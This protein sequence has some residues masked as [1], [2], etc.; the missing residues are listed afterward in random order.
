MIRMTSLL[1]LLLPLPLPLTLTLPII[2]RLLIDL[3]FHQLKNLHRL[4]P[5]LLRL[6]ALTHTGAGADARTREGKRAT[7]HTGE[8]Q[9]AN[10]QIRALLV[11]ADFTQRDRPRPEPLLYTPNIMSQDPSSDRVHT[12]PPSVEEFGVKSRSKR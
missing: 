11:L 3:H 1:L 8:R 4:F 2:L 10:Q 7:H 9:L 12:L 6:R 5:L